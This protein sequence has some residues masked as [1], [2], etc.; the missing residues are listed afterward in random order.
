MILGGNVVNFVSC[1]AFTERTILYPFRSS[2]FFL[3]LRV[4]DVRYPVDRFRNAMVDSWL[5]RLR[6]RVTR[7][8]DADQ[9]PSPRLLQ[10]QWPTAVAL[11]TSKGKKNI[12]STRPQPPT[13]LARVLPTSAVTG[14][15]HL[16]VNHHVDPIG[17]VPPLAY[18]IIYHGHVH[19]LK[20][21]GP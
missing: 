20:G 10:H 3:P 4:D 19:S 14:A 13:Y 15:H 9:V 17:S 7:R 2:R 21:L 5:A 12:D 8:D 11:R 16:V 6:A 1:K 18:T